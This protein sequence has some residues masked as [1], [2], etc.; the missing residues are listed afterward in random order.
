VAKPAIDMVE[1]YKA[2]VA[3]LRGRGYRVTPEDDQD[4][5]KLGKNKLQSIVVNA[6]EDAEASIHLLG[7]KTGARPDGL[8]L[9][10]MQ[11]AAAAD[12]ARKRPDFVRMIWAP[13]V[14]LSQ[15]SAGVDRDPLKVVGK[16]GEPLPT[17]QIDGDTASRFI[18]YML[19]RLERV[20]R[21][22]P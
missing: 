12:E 20:G 16:F 15:T 18:E 13:K 5:R 9:V 19:Q 8:D 14:L 17:D 21:H 10:P 22:G 3:E 4:L 11:L 6:L 2:V 7:E 1:S